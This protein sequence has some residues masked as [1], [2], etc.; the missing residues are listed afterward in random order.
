MP[1]RPRVW[2]V[3]TGCDSFCLR[4]NTPNRSRRDTPST[5]TMP[6]VLRYIIE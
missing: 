1:K 6:D 2:C 5:T 4:D 3:G